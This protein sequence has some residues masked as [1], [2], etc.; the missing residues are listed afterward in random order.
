MAAGCSACSSVHSAWRI[1]AGS[2]R[3]WRAVGAETNKSQPPAEQGHQ[4]KV[5]CYDLVHSAVE[6]VQAVIKKIIKISSFL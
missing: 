4:I 3:S 1:R 5:C 2:V 6:G